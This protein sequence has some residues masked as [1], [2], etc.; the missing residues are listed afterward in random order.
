M[1]SWIS[2]IIGLT[3]SLIVTPG[4]ATEV[5]AGFHALANLSHSHHENSL[6]SMADDRLSGVEGGAMRYDGLFRRIGQDVT[7]NFAQNIAVVV[8]TGIAGGDVTQFLNLTQQI[9]RNNSNWSWF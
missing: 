9:G 2:F 3:L 6:I 5:E 8:Q 1:K 7:I 4:M